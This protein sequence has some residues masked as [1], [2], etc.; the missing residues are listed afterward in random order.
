MSRRILLEGLDFAGKSTLAQGLL[1]RFLRE[2]MRVSLSRNSLCPQN[3][4]AELA[5]KVAQEPGR[6]PFE[7][8]SLF[9]ASHLWDIRHY[10]PDEPG[11]HL[12]DSCWLRSKAYDRRQGV[13]LP[14]DQVASV[15][16]EVVIFL[17]ASIPV[18]QWRCRKRRISGTEH[19]VFYKIDPFLALEHHLR[20]EFANHLHYLEI[21]TSRLSPREVLDLAWTNLVALGLTQGPREDLGKLTSQG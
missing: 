9:L 4:I 5:E 17:T 15:D 21:D 16:F 7:A 1:E 19:W 14:W 6:H 10:R 18:R 3:P 8:S 12:Q 20:Q 13:P 11:I 2:N